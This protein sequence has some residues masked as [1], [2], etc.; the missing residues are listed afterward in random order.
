MVSRISRKAVASLVLAISSLVAVFITG[1][2]AIVL[3]VLA[4]V[5]IRRSRGRLQ[6]MTLAV[7]GIVVGAILSV[8][9]VPFWL[10]LVIPLTRPLWG[11]SDTAT[12]ATTAATVV[13]K[14]SL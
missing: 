1:I 13:S 8:L 5:D 10:A 11:S 3:G 2:P 12:A 14:G 7:I 9:Y 6:G 4:I